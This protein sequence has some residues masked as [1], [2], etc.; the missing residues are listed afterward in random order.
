MPSATPTQL[1]PRFTTLTGVDADPLFDLDHATHVLSFGAPIVEDWLSPVWAQRAYGRFRRSPSR[2]RG[3]LVQIDAH[4][5][6]TARKA[7]E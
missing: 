5:S 6:M 4:R 2:P 1:R 3:R 7:D